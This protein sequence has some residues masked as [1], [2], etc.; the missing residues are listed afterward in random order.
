MTPGTV[1]VLDGSAVLALLYREPGERLVRDLLSGSY[2]STVNWSEIRQKVA[3]QGGDPATAD[4][5][6]ALGV[7]IESFTQ[8]DAAVAAEFFQVTR[9]AGLALG[10][11]AC[12]ALAKRRQAT[13]VTADLAWTMI[14]TGIPVFA[15]R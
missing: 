5:L 2:V 13:A 11:C 15:V 6:V 12:L 14:D 10:D 1:V 9:G 4:Y 3:Q 8:V 7:G